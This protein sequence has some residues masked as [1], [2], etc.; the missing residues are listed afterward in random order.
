MLS[1]YDDARVRTAHIKKIRS[2]LNIKP[3]DKRA[4][5]KAFEAMEH[6]GRLHQGGYRRHPQ[7]S[8]V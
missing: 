5:S 7:G 3:A 1:R 2:Y 8:E 6:A 4:R